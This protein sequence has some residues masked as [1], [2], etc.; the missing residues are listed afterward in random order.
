MLIVKSVT[1]L[2]RSLKNREKLLKILNM[3]VESLRHT[4]IVFIG[5]DV[6]ML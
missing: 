1:T 6:A 3:R 5:S 4:V 2:E